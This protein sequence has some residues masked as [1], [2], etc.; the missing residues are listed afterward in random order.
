MNLIG[1]KSSNKMKVKT[2]ID[3]PA[4]KYG[5]EYVL[6][7][8]GVNASSE[9]GI[10]HLNPKKVIKYYLRKGGKKIWNKSS[11]TSPFEIKMND[12]DCVARRDGYKD[13]TAIMYIREI[14]EPGDAE[15]DYIGSYVCAT[16]LSREQVDRLEIM[17]IPKSREDLLLAY[18]DY[19]K[20]AYQQDHIFNESSD[21]VRHFEGFHRRYLNLGSENGK[22]KLD[23]IFSFTFAIKQYS[24]WIFKFDSIRKRATMIGS[25]AKHWRNLLAKYTAVE[26]GKVGFSLVIISCF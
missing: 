6:T 24:G 10:L 20:S 17:I 19:Y 21:V 13:G 5:I 7:K 23:L 22:S 9:R 2:W 26:L 15:Y 14:F 16:Q 11:K 8:Y 25:L 12:L 3:L 4:S 1:S 18:L